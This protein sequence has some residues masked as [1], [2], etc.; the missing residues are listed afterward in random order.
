MRSWMVMALLSALVAAW[1]LS[2][3]GPAAT[4]AAIPEDARPRYQA[5]GITM[6]RTNAE[7]APEMQVLAK[8]GDYYP[9]GHAEFS[10]IEVRGLGN[11]RN[12]PWQLTAPSG[13]V[14][15]KEKRI[16]LH[17]PVEG[18]G[19]WPNGEPLAFHGS[20]V[21]ADQNKQQFYSD[22]PVQVLGTT[23]QAKGS[24]FVAGFDGKTL[25]MNHVELQYVLSSP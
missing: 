25:S 12:A 3:T 18:R 5:E 11:G 23:R 19:Q 21:W 6:L 8:F 7:G 9:D 1:L 15:P 4:S 24:S 16:L 2:R 10:E 17:R 13:S 14:P 22:R 20:E